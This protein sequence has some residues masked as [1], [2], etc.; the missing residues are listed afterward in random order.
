M[1]FYELALFL[2]IFQM[3]SF[4]FTNYLLPDLGFSADI[5]FHEPTKEQLTQAEEEFSKQVGS[6]EVT[7][8]DPISGFLGWTAKMVVNAVTTVLNPLKRFVLSLPYML[9]WFGVPPA[10]A[11]II[12]AVYWLVMLIGFVQFATGRSFKEVE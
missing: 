9:I 11:M 5:Y 10:F 8:E 7:S 6:T 12:G 2:F 4:Y 1:R 3:V